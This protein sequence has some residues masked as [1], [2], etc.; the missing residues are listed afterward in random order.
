M[1]KVSTGKNTEARDDETVGRMVEE[2][3]CGG[4]LFY[5]TRPQG[6][7]ACAKCYCFI[8]TATVFCYNKDSRVN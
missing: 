1:G 4:N 6:E 3:V 5:I 7:V 8:D 2:C